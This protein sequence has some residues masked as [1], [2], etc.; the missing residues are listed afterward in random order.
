MCL[1]RWQIA[2]RGTQGAKKEFA[3]TI[4]GKLALVMGWCKNIICLTFY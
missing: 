2:G 1:S 3:D 4:E